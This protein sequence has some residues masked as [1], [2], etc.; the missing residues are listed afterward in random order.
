MTELREKIREA[1]GEFCSDLCA[2]AG[3]KAIAAVL[4]LH[5][6]DDDDHLCIK[7]AVGYSVQSYYGPGE[8][9]P[10]IVAIAR[11][12]GLLDEDGGES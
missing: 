4:K 5:D 9:C 8:D 11:G 12:L 1:I 7:E 10:T 6:S 2:E 3:E